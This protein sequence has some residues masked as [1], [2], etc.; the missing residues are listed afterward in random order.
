[1]RLPR[2]IIPVIAVSMKGTFN[3]ANNRISAT[4]M[5]PFHTYLRIIIKTKN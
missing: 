5:S 1:M 2:R 4:I 3:N